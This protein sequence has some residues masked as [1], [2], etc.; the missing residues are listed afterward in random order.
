M[1]ILLP[2]LASSSSHLLHDIGLCIVAATVLAYV[3]RATRQPLIL[4]YIGAGILIGPE[5][6]GWVED[7][8]SILILS[9]LGLAFLLF[10]VGL[11]I[12]V[13]KLV[14]TGRNAI[15]V[16]VP[17]AMGSAVLGWF[18]A[19]LLGYEGLPALYLGVALAF[20]STMVV[21]KLLSDRAELDTLPGRV[22]LGILLMQDVLAII[23]LAVQPNLGGAVPI[24]QL[25]LS[26]L[27][28]VG[29]GAGAI[30][31]ARYVLPHL[32][33][34]VAMFPE[35]MLL[36]AIS[37]CFVVCYAAIQL[38][39]S[40]AMGALIA[41][42]SISTFP[43]TLEVVAK[44][45]SLRDF[46]VTLFF[47]SLGMLLA[48]ITWTLIASAIVLSMITVA[49]RLLTIWPAMRLLGYDN[50]VG[51]LSSLHL[52]QSSEF[53]L[54]IALLGLQMKTPEGVSHIGQDIVSLIVL[55]L[56][57]TSTV[58]TYLVQFSH[59]IAAWAVRQANRTPLADSKR[60]SDAATPDDHSGGEGGHGVPPA[61]V[62]LIGCFRVGSSLVNDLQDAGKQ[63]G[64]IDFN[65]QV[66]AALNKRSIP[67]IYGDISFMETLE[68]A[69]VQHARVLISAISDDFLRGTSNAMLL[70]SLRRLNPEAR[71]IVTAESTHKALE[72]YDA[73]AD[74]VIVPRVLASQ[75]IVEVVNHAETG[76]LD[77]IRAAEIDLLKQRQEIIG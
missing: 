17:Q 48:D 14:A 36:S 11:E 41:G 42:V 3:A 61:E 5:V 2:T 33:R 6:L 10:I 16:T 15:L 9:E 59:R 62:M 49:S 37:W 77:Q 69:G 65:P 64:V 71:I 47:V 13:K 31:I 22:T 52:S 23:V 72:L 34:W 54:V 44:I 40:I 57:I 60:Q 35:I 73:G 53:A 70:A 7:H 56:V 25:A 21:V 68:H 55:L 38:E 30:V 66:H 8:D 39:F 28:G 74:Y 1:P 63:F 26:M 4:A 58:S 27:K 51:I 24:G 75:K 67:C 46:F 43:Y 32:L 45:R 76:S 19:R 20:S 29:L 50:R 18:I 12:D